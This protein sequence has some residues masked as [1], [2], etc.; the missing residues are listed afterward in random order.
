MKKILL[1]PSWMTSLDLYQS[2]DDLEIRVGK[3]V[4]KDFSADYIIGFSLGAL[5]ALQDAGS[6][7]GKMIL[8]NPPLPKRSLGTWFI[9]WLGYIIC[10][11]SFSKVQ[12]FTK[13][14]FKYFKA[15]V[16]NIRLLGIDFAETLGKIP[17]NKLTVICGK[18]DKF[19][20]DKKAVEFLKS[21]GINVIET[22][23]GHNWSKNIEEAMRNLII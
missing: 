5:A 14:P 6:I 9:K 15:L 1:L 11:G 20:C 7:H 4:Q 2:Y 3:L 8:I 22:N 17:K 19:F 23:S 13:N 10:E 16:K 12:H 21:N 18:N